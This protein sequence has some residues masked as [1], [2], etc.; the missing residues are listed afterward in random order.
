MASALA[1]FIRIGCISAQSECFTSLILSLFNLF[2]SCMMTTVLI[3]TC[4]LFLFVS[5]PFSFSTIFV[6]VAS[7]ILYYWRCV[8]VSCF[9]RFA[10][11]ARRLVYESTENCSTSVYIAYADHANSVFRPTI[12]NTDDEHCA[13]ELNL[14]VVSL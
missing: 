4:K 9:A 10:C 13:M 11:S 8:G 6:A 5:L 12:Q 7:S 1:V 2:V 3:L 14:C